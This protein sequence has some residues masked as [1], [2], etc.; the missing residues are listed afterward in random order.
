[1]PRSEIFQDVKQ[2][3]HDKQYRDALTALQTKE[4]SKNYY[5]LSMLCLLMTRQYQPAQIIFASIRKE[6]RK[7]N[8]R[9]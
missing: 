4:L 2:L 5:L 6:S 1:M 8:R 9:V 7:N 3:I